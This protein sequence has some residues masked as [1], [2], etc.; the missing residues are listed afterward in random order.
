MGGAKTGDK[1]VGYS[2]KVSISQGRGGNGA[3]SGGGKP[4]HF[5][6]GSYAE[7]VAKGSLNLLSGPAM[8]EATVG[9]AGEGRL[10][11]ILKC[12]PNDGLWCKVEAHSDKNLRGWVKAQNLRAK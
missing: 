1:E 12:E 5:A 4:A 11:R 6:P 8:S 2:I 10:M 7:I 9:Q 3:G